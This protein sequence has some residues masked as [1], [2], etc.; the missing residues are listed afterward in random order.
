[1]YVGDTNVTV[2]KPFW[3]QCLE[4]G[5]IEWHKDGQPIQQLHFIRHS[6]DD[7]GYVQHDEQ[8]ANSRFFKS[9]IKVKHALK[10]H[11]GKYKCSSK[12]EKSHVLHVHDADS[13]IVELDSDNVSLEDEYDDAIRRVSFEPPIIG[14]D[15]LKSTMMMYVDEVSESSRLFSNFEESYE[16]FRVDSIEKS[17]D[18][19]D[20]EVTT[21]PMT[22]EAIATT[23]HSPQHEMTHKHNKHKVHTPHDP[24]IHENPLN[25]PHDPAHNLKNIHKDSKSIKHQTH[26][27]HVLPTQQSHS[28]L[29][30]EAV[31]TFLLTTE[32]TTTTVMQQ[33]E[34]SHEILTFY[35]EI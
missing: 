20:V 17:S 22:T 2:G 29:M 7:Y 16:Q 24:N 25:N 13:V 10:Q 12:H 27:N 19:E 1:V 8:Y 33:R 23:T 5:P 32:H 14:D 4:E 26:E 28:V 34:G 30:H 31:P 18:I 6:K 3:I 35:E 9:T 15:A 11:G 21:Q